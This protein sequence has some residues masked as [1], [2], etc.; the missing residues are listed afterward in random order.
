MGAKR[1]IRQEE[2]EKRL[3]E[4]RRRPYQIINT[5][6]LSDLQINGLAV[7]QGYDFGS[8]DLTNSEF[9]DVKFDGC[10]F[11]G[12]KLAG[13]LFVG[14]E[15]RKCDWKRLSFSE[16]H[17][18]FVTFKDSSISDCA[19]ANASISYV[20]AGQLRQLHELRFR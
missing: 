13:C 7:P 1:P 4:G 16:C 5:L 19:F 9:S 17:F 2:L 20:D 15:F 10:Q 8:G 6:N 14:G 18:Q 3:E 12:T 11:D